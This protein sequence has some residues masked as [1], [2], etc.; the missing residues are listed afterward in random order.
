[1]KPWEEE[2][3]SGFTG[4]RAGAVR[5][6]RSRG[7]LILRAGTMFRD[8]LD[9]SFTCTHYLARPGLLYPFAKLNG[10]RSHPGNTETGVAISHENKPWAHPTP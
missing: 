4:L 6:S 10:P 1:M 3:H 2:G 9:K 8:P 7:Q 5:R